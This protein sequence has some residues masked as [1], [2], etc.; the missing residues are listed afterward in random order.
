MKFHSQITQSHLDQTNKLI[1]PFEAFYDSM[2]DQQKNITDTAFR[3]GKYGKPETPQE[4]IGKITQT[5]ID[6]KQAIGIDP[7]ME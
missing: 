2:S 3:T 4:I 7:K 5:K 6:A 1:A